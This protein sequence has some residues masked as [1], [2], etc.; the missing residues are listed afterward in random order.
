MADWLDDPELYKPAKNLGRGNI[1]LNSRPVVKNNDGSISTVRSISANFDGEEVLIPTVSEDGRIMSNDEAVDTYRRTGKFLGK[2]KTPEEATAYANS[3]HNQQANQ[4]APKSSGGDDWLDD[5]SLYAAPAKPATPGVTYDVNGV[6]DY[7]S[8]LNSSEGGLGQS[9]MR[10]I[11]G[12][13]PDIVANLIEMPA[14][15]N[16]AVIRSTGAEPSQTGVFSGMRDLLR[17]GAGAVRDIGYSKDMDAVGYGA[18]TVSGRDALAAVNPVSG[19]GLGDR[20]STVGT[21]VPETLAGSV[22][23]MAATLNPLTLGG[24]VASRTNEVAKNRAANDKREDVTLGDIGIAAPAAAVEA[25]LE[26]FTTMRL[27]PHGTTMA[28]PGAVEAVKRIAKELGIQSTLGGVEELAPYFAEGAGTKTGV[29][30]QGALETFAG[31]ALAEGATGAVVQGA[32][33]A[34]GSL[35]GRLAP[36]LPATPEDIAT[37]EIETALDEDTFANRPAAPATDPGYRTTQSGAL[38]IDVPIEAT[39]APVVNDSAYQRPVAAEPV[40]APPVAAQEDVAETGIPV[41]P[42]APATAAERLYSDYNPEA[43]QTVTRVDGDLSFPENRLTR[44]ALDDALA[45]T[46]DGAGTLLRNISEQP[47]IRPEQKWLAEKLAPMMKPLGVKLVEPNPGLPYAGAYNN[48]DNTVWARQAD[49]ETVLHETFHGVTSALIT[50]KAARSNPVVGKAV[51]E[52]DDMLGQLQAG[53]GMGEINTAGAHPEIQRLFKDR[54]GPLSNTKEFV[55]YGLTNRPFQDF[56]RT[57]PPPNGR[58][59]ARNMW[60]YFK[61][62]VAS[63][64]GKLTP[65]QRTFLD[66]LIETGGDLADFAAANPAVV[67]QAQVA[68]AGKL[69]P[70]AS[71]EPVPAAPKPAPAVAPPAS[72]PPKPPAAAQPSA[73]PSSPAPRVTGTKNAFVDGERE[74]RSEKPIERDAPRPD[75]TA[76]DMAQDA[77]SENPDLPDEIIARVQAGNP[78]LTSIERLVLLNESTRLRTQRENLERKLANPELSDVARAKAQA[79]L[80]AVNESIFA[81]DSVTVTAG[82]DW[83]REGRAMQQMMKEDFTLA[84]LERRESARKGEALTAE[85]RS[86]MKTM[87]GAIAETQKRLEAA[88]KRLDEYESGAAVAATYKRLLDDMRSRVREKPDLPALK[89]KADAAKA[90]L[91][92]LAGT[93]AAVMTDA[94]TLSPQQALID[95]GAYHYANGAQT[96]E[97]W[98]KAMEADVPEQFRDGMSDLFELSKAGAA[99][100]VLDGPLTHKQVYDLAMALVRSGVKG[101]AEVMKAVTA[102]VQKAQPGMTERDV[103][104]AFTEY[105]KQRFPTKDADKLRLAELRRLVKLEEDITRLKE[106][107]APIKSSAKRAEKSEEIRQ[108][109]AEYTR[110]RRAYD[111]AHPDAEAD[112]RYQRGRATSLA[113][114]LAEIQERIRVGDYAKAVRVPKELNEANTKAAY[115]VQQAK[116]VFLRHQ[117]EAEMARRSP[118][119]KILGGA[120]EALNLA[121]AVMTSFDLSAVLRQGGFISLGNPVRAAKAFMPMLRAFASKE[122]E[123]KVKHDIETDP[124]YALSKSAGLELTDT[125]SGLNLSKLEEAFMSRWIEHIPKAVGGGFLRGSQRAFTTFLNKLRFDSFK[126]MTHALARD[127]SNP[128]MV[129]AK[130]IASYINVATGRGKIGLSANAAT[131]LNTVFFAPKLVASRFNLLAGQPLY[132]GTAKTRRL[133]LQ[134]YARFLTGV[135]VVIGLGAMAADPED[136]D[137]PFIGLDPRSTDFLKM[138]FGKTYIDPM[139]GLSQVTVFLARELSGESLTGSGAVVPLREKYRIANLWREEPLTD[140]PGYGGQNA[141]DVAARFVRTKL[142]PIPGAIVNLFTGEDVV[143]NEVSPQQSVT[144]LVVP[145]SMQ[146]VKDVMSEHGVPAGMAITTLELLGMGVQYRDPA[147]L[148][149]PDYADQS[150]AEKNS[151]SAYLKEANK[152][153]QAKT[154]LQ[155]FANKLPEDMPAGDIKY[156]VEKKAAELGLEGATVD[157]YKRNTTAR[158][159]DTGAR[160]R[161]VKRSE[162]GSV[163]MN[164]KEAYSLSGFSAVEKKVSS[165]DEDIE[166]LS[167]DDVTNEE[168][169][170]IHGKYVFTPLT[171]GGDEQASKKDIETVLSRLRFER[172]FSQDQLTGAGSE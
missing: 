78:S 2:F 67:R 134:E 166:A 60:E 6:P 15:A 77:L 81:M 36:E 91:R 31:G 163:R 145:L 56:L 22:M 144:S 25:L 158:D 19:M 11:F 85:E 122:G 57:L 101:E 55:T 110:L 58:T 171:N 170:K 107:L 65:Q 45:D 70:V 132:G 28:T 147:Q 150:R 40:A 68:E 105:G 136:D 95:L 120:Q 79:E 113:R 84:A 26:R 116:E 97:S 12:R 164:W 80:D 74:R 141:Y 152:V 100:P 103:R 151:Y 5:P 126:A 135:A 92:E 30:T 133:V 153:K 112:A 46:D 54:Q 127:G 73:Q 139:A 83:G 37:A 23:D 75:R 148:K 125:G 38:E 50:N 48:V 14:T 111:A 27:L 3:L 82:R 71:L 94:A 42:P 165:V 146:N 49:P 114:Q 167:E 35:S 96:V 24:Y 128:S 124:L 4:Y 99:K 20:L 43:S 168:L 72:S 131:G 149:A 53:I 47:D 138:R 89:K 156:E 34:T 8:A 52:L 87:A 63:M 169:E 29:S 44:R 160:M 137:K 32:K 61:Q 62:A 123:F 16:E 41:S 104:R 109:E 17:K 13:G 140:K 21:F 159:P 66:A 157:I 69:A 51:A 1:D 7:S 9:L 118:L 98:T 64:F 10:G 154:D 39:P 121:R 119:R 59:E 115:A 108:R 33:E 143:G 90:A 155:D 18:P 130:A 162:T 172:K 86:E 106:G 129:E 142:A 93:D 102:D 161:G 117:F 88:Q 76:N